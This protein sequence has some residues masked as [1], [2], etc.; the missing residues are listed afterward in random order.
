[1]K[2][3]IL[4]VALILLAILSVTAQESPLTADQV[5]QKTIY[6][7][8]SLKT[9]SYDY[10]R[11]L[12]YTSERFFHELKAAAYLDFTSAGKVPGV[13][14]R[15]AADTNSNTFNGAELFSLD[16]KNKI[17]RLNSK[18][19]PADFQS[20]SYLVN[21]PVTLKNVLPKV[22]ADKTITRS[23]S[24]EKNFYV[25]E[26]ALDKFGIDLFGN[27]SDQKL[28]RRITYRVTVAKSDFMPV[29]VLQK[30]G[31]IDFIKTTF[32]NIRENPAPPAENTWYYS[33]Y[34]GEYKF[35][36]PSKNNLIGAGAAA[37]DFALPSAGSE[38]EVSLRSYRGKLV[39]LEFW[40]FHCGAC[41]AA[42]PRLN[43]IREKYKGGDFNLLAV[44]IYDSRELV[45]FFIDSKK[46]GYPVL[47]T[48]E[49]A[50]KQYGV[51]RYPTV[52]L[53][54]KDGK[55]IF[56]GIFDAVKIDALIAKN[57]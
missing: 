56:S 6:K 35:A 11:E 50:A 23:I 26:F 37:P 47:Y 55:V 39:L 45:D 44:N 16:G 30:N 49:A 31:D 2:K 57:L 14:Y 42:V 5:I 22:L 18:P 32:S 34:L 38:R 46:V 4:T 43:A 48:G 15:F 1:M 8:A 36:E 20:D 10:R 25:V 52:V 3:Y 9:V 53:I 13:K 28:A 19:A 24:E 40:I 54:G 51:D 7:L 29:E 41:I 33:T 17:I 21:S 27:Y 12:N